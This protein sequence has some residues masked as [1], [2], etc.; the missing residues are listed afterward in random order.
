MN[1]IKAAELLK[2]APDAELAQYL[3]SPT[4]DFPEYLVASEIKRRETMREKYAAA[5]QG[6]PAKTSIIEELLQKDNQQMRRQQPQQMPPEAMGLGSVPP[7]EGMQLSQAPMM[8][9]AQQQPQQFYDGGAV[10]FAEGGLSGLSNQIHD[11]LQ[12]YAQGGMVDEIHD[13]LQGYASGGE[14]KHFKIGGYNITPED[15][16]VN[17]SLIQQTA[18]PN[19]ENLDF[20]RNQAETALGPSA[21][22]GYQ[23]VLAKQRAEIE[24]RQKN[25]L[26]DFLIQAGLGMATSKGNLLQAAA[27]GAAQGFK[28]H[29]QSKQ[30]DE[31]AKRNLVDSEFKFKQAE[32]AEKAG[33]FGL[34]RDLYKD[35]TGQRNDAITQNRAAETL[36]LN[37]V[38]HRDDALAKAQELGISEKRL[39]IDASRAGSE[40]ALRKEQIENYKENR[41]IRRKLVNLQGKPKPMSG[42]DKLA[43]V[44]NIQRYDPQYAALKASLEKAAKKD[45]A[46]Q[47][48]I[49]GQLDEYINNQLNKYGDVYTA[50]DL[51][52]SDSQ[53]G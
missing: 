41:D 16:N 33:L 25:Y 19:V 15:Y 10:S 40:S 21:L 30:A 27:E 46:L 8:E 47:Y 12:G 23:D 9:A 35:A 14:V 2:G 51:M 52:G 18:I 38:A 20:Y 28:F 34:S 1:L 49:Q 6:Q 53:T 48:T 4:G 26:P 13:Y 42:K 3:Q 5:N 43:A 50:A 31:Q 32:R 39:A 44:T 29:Q 22:T 11:Y 36:R 24:G 17:Q 37:S 7:P 45:P